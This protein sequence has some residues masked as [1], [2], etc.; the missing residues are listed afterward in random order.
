MEKGTQRYF[1]HLRPDEVFVL[2]F[3]CDFSTPNFT[4]GGW[5]ILLP[6]LNI[7]IY[8]KNETLFSKTIQLLTCVS[9][10]DFLKVPQLD[11]GEK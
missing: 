2:D 1:S 9:K 11:G 8:F 3:S 7:N 6:N 5:I 4:G 10:Y